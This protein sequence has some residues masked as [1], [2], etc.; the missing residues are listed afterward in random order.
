MKLMGF[1]T[2]GLVLGPAFL[3][4]HRPDFVGLMGTFA[5]YGFLFAAGLEL[6]RLQTLRHAREAFFISVGA[7]FF[8]LLIGWCGAVYLL[9]ESTYSDPLFVAVAMAVSALPVVIQLLKE[10]NLYLTDLGRLIISVA[11]LC[12]ILAWLLFLVIL[13]EHS[14]SL[15]LLSHMPVFI[16]LMGFFLS[17]RS[18][19]A[20]TFI[21][22]LEVLTRWI[23]APLFFITIGW[24]L[25]V[26]QHFDSSQVAT[27]TLIAFTGK[28]IGSYFAARWRSLSRRD[29]LTIGLSL[30]ARGAMEIL[31]AT[32][33]L[34]AGLI[35]MTLFTSLVVMALITSL[36]P[37]LIFRISKLRVMPQ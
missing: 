17:D 27:V 21:Q 13:P 32:F 20:P 24:S 29:S 5:A 33:G 35:T 9:P 15:W 2:M 10:S 25:D 37:A 19:I 16:F 4:L 31:M 23:F 11:T 18:F 8:P 12:D 34:K 22:T 14:R 6:N 28:I 26:G 30:N 7:F 3:N 36:V 1:I